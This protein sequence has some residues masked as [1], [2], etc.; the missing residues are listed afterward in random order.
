VHPS[1]VAVALVA[2]Q[3]QLS[4][5]G[6]SGSKA[7]RIDS[8]FVSPKKTADKEN[9]LLPGEIITDIRIPA[10]GGTVKSLYRKIAARGSWDFALASVAA[11]LQL[12]NGTVR[13]ARLVLG[14][15]GPYPWRIEAA[16][17]LLIG[18]KLDSAAAAAAADAA[19]T[20]AVPLRDNAYKLEMVK[21]AVEESLT[22]LI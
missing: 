19:I 7:I 5:S 17:K 16:E 4:I 13:T 1:D 12:E 15:V 9:V 10:V 14:G 8:F 11:I 2:L 22:A 6:P 20:G 18:K 3:A 21:G